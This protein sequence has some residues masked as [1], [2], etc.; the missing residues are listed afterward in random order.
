[1]RQVINM[2]TSKVLSS[3]LLS[4]FLYASLI[5]SSN[6][7]YDDEEEALIE[8]YG[9]EETISIATGSAQPISRAPAVATVITARDIK[10]MGATDVDEVLETVPG[11]HVSRNSFANT[12]IYTFRGIYSVTSPQVL[13]LING[14]SVNNLFQGDRGLIWG[15]MPV[16]AISRIEVVRGPGS[17][18]YGADAFSGVIN[19]ITKQANEI[20]GLEV[21]SRIGRF[22]TRDFW[23]L[24][25]GNI[26]GIDLAFSIEGR[27]TDGHDEDVNADFQT[28]LDG[29]TGTNASLA[30]G[31]VNNEK[32]WLDTRLDI[33]KGNWKFR[34]GLQS[35]QSVGSGVGV[36]EALDPSGEFSSKRWNA[37]LTYNNNTWFDKLDLTSQVSFFNTS[38]EVDEDQLIFPPGAIVPGLGG[39]FPDGVIGN[40]EGWERHLR[41]N[42]TAL[43]SG[44]KNH[45][46]RFGSG[47]VHSELYKVKEEK[48]FGLDGNGV[49]IPLG[50]PLVDVTDT[51]AVFI[52]EK[53]RS[54]VFVSLQ[55]VWQLSNDW[56]LTAGLRYDDYND[57][58][59]TW[60]PRL[61]LVWAA[62]HDLTAKLLYGQ[63]FRAP[64]LAEFR[65]ENNP[66]ALGNDQLDPEE[67]ETLELAFDYRPKDNFRIGLNLFK[68][69]WDDII[70]YAPSASLP[71]GF[72]QAQNIGEQDGS[73]FEFEFDWDVSRKLKILGNFAY[74]DSED[75]TTD[76][77]VG[78][79][80]ERQF[81]V[82][83]EWEF[84]P[85]WNVSP[86]WNFVID[87]ERPP[88]D[89]RSNIDDYDILDLT[90][91]HTVFNGRWELAL[92]GRNVLNKRA[93][94]PTSTS[95]AGD[96]P[97]ARRSFWGEFR[98]NY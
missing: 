29:F 17:A 65:L 95:I 11:L 47:Y 59:D 71:V 81:Y 98:F 84:K 18:L 88:G 97:L 41:Y 5:S 1:M 49:P 66:V 43:F 60:N 9:D 12:P 21:G 28:I 70:Q 54:N 82:R 57:F 36:G 62:R 26:G 39:P 2:P 20:D 85:G 19:V 69:E 10:K 40:P 24:Y 13:M 64:S 89:T 91:R 58:G 68:Y 51:P 30:P 67:M 33:S 14:I 23:A 45:T 77:D 75:K 37:D 31:S 61:A 78:N 6:A 94:E 48:N 63:A 53:H 52:P 3:F 74:Q 4:I 79:A 27:Q 73:G 38:Q 93:F 50:S 34:A 16:E 92:S 42:L 90:L 15:G 35:R 96:L 7:V 72:L 56:E 87:R 46:V 25:G 76:K 8:L 86:Q 80:P 22:D 44:I 32:D 83:T 55:D